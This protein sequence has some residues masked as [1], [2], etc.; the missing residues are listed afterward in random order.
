MAALADNKMERR[1]CKLDWVDSKA[2]AGRIVD[3]MNWTEK[4]DSMV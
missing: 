4:R 2:R 3:N 1:T